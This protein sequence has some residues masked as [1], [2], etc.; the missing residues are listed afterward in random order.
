MERRP[1]SG[2]AALEASS[3]ARAST[4]A[5]DVAADL[6]IVIQ[7]NESTHF[8][9]GGNHDG[10][11]Q[12]SSDKRGRRRVFKKGKSGVMGTG[13]PSEMGGVERGLGAVPSAATM[14]TYEDRSP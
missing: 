1:I 13:L 4:Y 7:G 12:E 10:S 2:T 9:H 3:L 11:W 14:P 5:D 6:G 8:G